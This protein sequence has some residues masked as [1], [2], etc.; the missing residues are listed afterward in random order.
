MNREEIQQ[1]ATATFLDR[2]LIPPAFYHHTPNG[3]L[4]NKAVAA[5]LK[6]MGVKPGVPDIL[7][8]TQGG[9]LH[10]ISGLVRGYAIELKDDEG[11]LSEGQWKWAVNWL[12]IGGHYAIARTSYDVETALRLWGIQL[13]GTQGRVGYPLLVNRP[14]ELPRPGAKVFTRER[15]AALARQ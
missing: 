14:A 1:R 12:A 10:T 6:L 2:T 8:F 7:L 11:A 3:G 5:R 4:R 9:T 15:V 13:R